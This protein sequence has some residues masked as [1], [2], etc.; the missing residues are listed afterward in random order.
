M[1]RKRARFRLFAGAALV[2]GLLLRLWF[3]HHMARY[4]GDSLVYGDIARNLL[5]HRVYGFTEQGGTPGSILIHPTLIRLPGYPLF[6]AA[7]FRLF[8][9]EN[10]HAALNV[11]VAVDLVSCWLASALAGRLF[12]PSARLPVLWIAV[13][14]PF[15]ANYSSTA[16]AETLVFFTIALAFYAVARWQ[17][18]G[19]GYNRWLFIVAAALSYS[20]LLRPEQGLLAAAVLSAMLWQSLASRASRSPFRAAMPVLVA[21]LCTAL[22]FVPWTARNAYYFHV[23]QPL[24]PRGANDPGEPSLPGFG[25][26]Y[27]AWAVDFA[28]TDEICWPMDGEPIDFATLPDRAFAA[29]TPAASAELRRRTAA[30]FADY[31]SGLTLTPAL[32]ARFDALATVLI[33]AHPVRYYFTLHIARVLDMAFRPRTETMPVSDEWWQW[34][35]HPGQTVFAT[36]YAALNLAYFAAGFAGFLA[37]RRRGWLSP[38]SPGPH[39]YREL[40]A[41]MVAS[42]LLRAALLLFINN[43]EQRYTLEFFPIFF[44]WIGVLF[45]TR[46]TRKLNSCAPV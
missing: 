8:G 7:C 21:A 11:Q 6:L 43:S 36:S 13:L 27:D 37:W 3:V 44:V 30:L 24:A 20:I 19:L 34:S 15:T 29:S 4:V 18:A 40:A 31:N 46:L 2:A 32:D 38:E 26:W 42:I 35:Q 14:C 10:Y 1:N 39:V 17:D 22:P 33:H 45:A 12:G 16:L 41:A 5:L 9:M 28:S 25:R 23:F